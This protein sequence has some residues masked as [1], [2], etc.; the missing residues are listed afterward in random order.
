MRCTHEMADLGVECDDILLPLCLA[1]ELLELQR[2]D[3]GLLLKDAALQRLHLGLV[4]SHLPLHGAVLGY[5][6]LCI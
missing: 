2:A 3:H 4:L 1:L 6:V 5:Q